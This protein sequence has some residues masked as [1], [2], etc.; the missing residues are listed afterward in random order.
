MLALCWVLYPR[1]LHLILSSFCLKEGAPSHLLT[2]PVSC[3]PRSSHQC[4][5]SYIQ[6]HWFQ[7]RQS[8]TTYVPGFSLTHICSLIWWHSLWELLQFSCDSHCRPLRFWDFTWLVALL[9]SKQFCF[10]ASSIHPLFLIQSYFS[11][12]FKNVSASKGQLCILC[13]FLFWV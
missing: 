2:P 11:P 4:R 7:A 8:F 13:D 5:I 1:V 10:F 3:F 6:Y 12:K 9:F